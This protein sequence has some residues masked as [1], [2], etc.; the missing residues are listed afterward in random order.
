MTDEQV[1]LLKQ[2]RMEGKTQQTTAA[3]AGVSERAARKWQCGPFH[4]R[5]SRSAGGEPGSIPLTG[6]GKRESCP[7]SG[8][9]PPAG[10]GQRKLSSGWRRNFPAGSAP[11]NSARCNDDYRTGERSTVQ[12]RR[13][14]SPKSIHRPGRPISTSPTATPWESPSAAGPTATCCSSWC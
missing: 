5:P 13:S 2:K 11:P 7:C 8:A 1:R 9:R 3:V 10:S 14:T 12:I 4:R 6:S